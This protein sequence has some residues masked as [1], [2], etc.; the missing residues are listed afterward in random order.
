MD[1]QRETSLL[2]SLNQLFAHE[3]DRV[4][5]ERIA[6]E[7][8]LA[9]ERAFHEENARRI[10]EAEIQA[11]VEEAKR[12]VA[13]AQRKREE[14]IRLE[15]L[16]TAELERVIDLPAELEA[17]LHYNGFHDIRFEPDFTAKSKHADLDSLAIRCR[18]APAL[19]PKASRH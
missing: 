19:A 12:K 4:R 17:L 2:F 3:R 5:R 6:E 11:E 16:R 14:E 13:E 7:T 8:R 1:E 15:V 18:R 9:E 10:R